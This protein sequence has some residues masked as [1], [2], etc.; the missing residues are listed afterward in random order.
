MAAADRVGERSEAIGLRPCQREFK[1]ATFILP[2]S[3]TDQTDQTDL[4]PFHIP[5][6]FQQM[7][8]FFQFKKANALNYLTGF[9]NQPNWQDLVSKVQALYHI[10]FDDIQFTFTDENDKP[11]TIYSNEGLE[12]YY[13]EYYRPPQKIRLIVQDR[14]SPDILCR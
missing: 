10:P 11:S 7:S 2:I 4:C 5:F 14:N 3:L 12:Y 1:K 6:Q 13:M 8:V 9:P